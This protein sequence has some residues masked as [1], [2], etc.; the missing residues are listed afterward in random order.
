MIKKTKALVL[1]SGGLDSMLSALIL[2]ERGIKVI[3]VCFFSFFFNCDKASSAAEEAGFKLK[4]EDF[5][6][7]QLKIVKSPR[8]GRGSGMNPCV[9]CHLLM[10]KKARQ[11]M[12]KQGCDFVVTGEVLGQ[13]PFSQNK[14]ALE[15]MERK[16]GLKGMIIRPLSLKLLPKTI[17]EKKGLIQ[18]EWFYDIKG[19]SRKP[20]LALAGKFKIKNIPTPAGGCIL[21]DPV[22]SQRLKKLFELKKSFSGSDVDLIKS[23]R[24]FFVGNLLAVVARNEAEC[25][26]LL[27]K[28]KRGDLALEPGSFP[29]PTVLV[30]K[31]KKSSQ[32]EMIDCGT[33]LL[34]RYAKN[35]PED[36]V[37]E[38]LPFPKSC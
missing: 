11:I 30:R 10:L 15:L 31:I 20:Q 33:E 34:L 7:E 5:S 8:Y 22:F 24:V 36:A 4:K 1:F 27:K 37:I 13:R 38:I 2:R 9:D 23:G 35:V 21:T 6:K 16:A 19:R 32:D 25:G 14:G 17:P 26:E 29:G 3:P 18:R 28:R 12:K